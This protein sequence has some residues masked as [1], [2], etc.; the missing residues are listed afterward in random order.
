MNKRLIIPFIGFILILFSVEIA[1]AHV[2][3]TTVHHSS[4][5]TVP[6]NGSAKVSIACPKGSWLS[7]GGYV[8]CENNLFVV[9]NA[10]SRDNPN[11]WEVEAFSPKILG[12]IQAYAVCINPAPKL[13]LK[14]LG[15]TK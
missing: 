14:G 1:G 10:P 7:G 12:K 11:T 4:I 5:A 8:V 2:L 13:N 9:G 15:R 6:A 3:I